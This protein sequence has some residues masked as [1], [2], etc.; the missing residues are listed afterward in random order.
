MGSFVK[1]ESSFFAPERESSH[2]FEKLKHLFEKLK[3]LALRP[4]D[5]TSS[6]L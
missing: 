2:L 4:D 6:H 1:E 3:H 5:K